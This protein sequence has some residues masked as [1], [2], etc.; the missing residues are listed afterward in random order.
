MTTRVLLPR[1][2]R[3]GPVRRSAVV[4]AAAAIGL[5]FGCACAGPAPNEESTTAAEPPATGAAAAA[6]VTAGPTDESAT[7][8]ADEKTATLTSTVPPDLIGAAI[9]DAVRRTS[10]ART[11]VKVVTAEAVT[12]PDGALG[13]PQPGMMYTQALQ[14]GYRIVLEAGGQTL[15]YHASAK[16]G[17]AFC[18]PERVTPPAPGNERT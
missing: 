10:A 16:G 18:P 7:A 13:C 9:S 12:W 15:N 2:P 11:D 6:P 8:N 3:T 5:G 4:G 14:P 17:P 1:A